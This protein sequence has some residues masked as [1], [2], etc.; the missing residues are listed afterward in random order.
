MREVSIFPR[1]NAEISELTHGLANKTVKTE[2]AHEVQVKLL[3]TSKELG[4]N[5]EMGVDPPCRIKEV[6]ADMN[7]RRMGIIESESIKH[8]RELLDILLHVVPQPGTILGLVAIAKLDAVAPDDEV[9]P[10]VGAR[11]GAGK[12]LERV[13]VP[14]PAVVGEGEGTRILLLGGGVGG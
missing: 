2:T 11:G 4:T 9:A 7:G 13:G 5:I 1:L 6:L 14:D 3:T 10:D 8:A 12:V